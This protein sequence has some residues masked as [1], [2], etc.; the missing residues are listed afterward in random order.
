M[1]IV[2]AGAG[3]GGLTAA[4]GLA[5]DGHRVQVVERDDTPMPDNVED[6]FA[7]DRRGAPQVRHTHG[8]P[9]LIRIVLRDRFPDVLA[10]LRAAGVNEISIL[11]AAVTPDVA[12]YERHAE[13]L[14]VLSCRRTTLEFVLRQCALAE[15][16]IDICV[17][18]AVDGWTPGQV[19]VAATGRRGDIPSWFAPHGITID[20]SEHPTGTIYLSRFYRAASAEPM[21][22]VG[23]RQAGLGFVIGLAMICNLVAAALGGILIPLVLHRLRFDPAVASSPFVTTVTDVVGF[24]SFLGIATLWFGLR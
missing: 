24:F 21:G 13:D 12:D 18:E 3:I 4:I 8:F 7:W 17:G 22:Y 20:E 15:S 9:A 5:R 19:M 2:V 11:P 16:N 23:G 10:A 1:D 6:A 14:Q